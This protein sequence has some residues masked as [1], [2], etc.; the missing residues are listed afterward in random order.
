M[1]S[2]R[3]FPA[4]FVALLALS[5]TAYAGSDAEIAAKLKGDWQGYWR[6]G[7]RVGRLNAHITGSDGTKIKG[8]AT[9]YGMATKEVKLPMDKAEVKDGVF[10]LLHN[11]GL[12]ID[13]KIS[14]DGK[15]MKGTW[16]S[17][18]GGGPVELKKTN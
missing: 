1:Q 15:V 7:E 8:D 14:A 13:S 9:W 16:G 17:A 3:I 5:G 6:F 18:A 12:S 4:L 11:H 2:Y 10:K